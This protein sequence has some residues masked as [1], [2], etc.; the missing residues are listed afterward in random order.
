MISLKAISSLIIAV[1]VMVSL[2]QCAN[3]KQNQK[4]NK[5]IFQEQPSFEIE[6][7]HFQKWIAG[8]Q[9]G[10][11]G[12]HMY[13]N[14]NANKNQVVF[15]SVYFKGLTAKMELGKM[16]YFASFKTA[17]NQKQDMIMSGENHGE[18]GNKPLKN[19][20]K[21][22]DALKDSECVIEYTE[23]DVIKYYKY[24]KVIEKQAEHYPSAPPV[25][26]NH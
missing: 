20:S 11:S 23:N 13:I 6:S 24:T 4:T 15:D 16:G 21:F 12:I 5:M 2:L 9:G 7:I 14:V 1:F 10:G 17:L 3:S 25:K 8:V 22:Q 18:Y 19:N 26:E